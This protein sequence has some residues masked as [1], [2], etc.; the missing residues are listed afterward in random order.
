MLRMYLLTFCETHLRREEVKL[1]NCK[2][3]AL[4]C[5]C[6][7]GCCCFICSERTYEV[8]EVKLLHLQLPLCPMPVRNIIEMA[9]L[10]WDACFQYVKK[11][12][13]GFDSN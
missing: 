13:L 10:D 6:E 7:T 4:H 11:K 9:P 3:G 5:A 8:V 2:T 1:L 12:L